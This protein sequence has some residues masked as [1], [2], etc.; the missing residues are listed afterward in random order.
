[1]EQGETSLR[2]FEADSRQTG[3]S[4]LNWVHASARGASGIAIL[5]DRR[6]CFCADTGAV[7]S[8][9]VTGPVL[10]YNPNVEDDSITAAFETGDG[11][12][13]FTLS[14][15]E[16]EQHLGNLLGNL[17]DL[18]EAQ[19]KLEDAGVDP[20]HVSPP[21]GGASEGVSAIYQ[22]M[23]LKEMLNQGLFSEI[24]FA[25]ERQVMIERFVEQARPG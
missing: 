10:R 14:R 18:R 15:G 13:A 21:P 16:E 1:M 19:S 2:A 3:E 4:V 25:L 5:T 17:A 24:E 20:L 22:L 23:R 11:P 7:D 6:L 8:V 9:S 12:I